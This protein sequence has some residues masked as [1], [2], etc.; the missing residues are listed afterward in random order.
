MVMRPATGPLGSGST[1]SGS[2]DRD[3]RD[4]INRIGVDRIGI[5]GSGST[6]RG[7][8]DPDRPGRDS[9]ARRACPSP[10]AVNLIVSRQTDDNRTIFVVALAVIV[11]SERSGSAGDSQQ[12]SLH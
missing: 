4:R 5:D 1:G 11:I 3:Q 2:T 10:R 8:L 12:S 6:D 7:Q 9:T